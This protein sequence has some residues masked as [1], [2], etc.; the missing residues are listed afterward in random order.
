MKTA[1][2][3]LRDRLTERGTE[4]DDAETCGFPRSRISPE[5]AMEFHDRLEALINEF[6][7]QESDPS[8]QVYGLSLTFFRAPSYVQPDI[9]LPD[10]PVA[11]PEPEGEK[12]RKNHMT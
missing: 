1:Y 12:S 2:D 8:G 6:I 9:T 4:I 11:H 5:R 10:E 3:Q 7:A